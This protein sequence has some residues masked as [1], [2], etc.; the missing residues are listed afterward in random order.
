MAHRTTS[1]HDCAGRQ[2]APYRGSAQQAGK[3]Y[4]CFSSLCMTGPVHLSGNFRRTAFYI[5]QAATVTGNGVEADTAIVDLN[6]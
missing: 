3:G 6:I 2:A 5:G 1:A 4:F